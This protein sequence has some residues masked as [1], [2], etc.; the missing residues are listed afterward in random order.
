VVLPGEPEV[1]DVPGRRLTLAQPE[2]HARG[3]AYLDG[4][5]AGL[6]VALGEVSVAGRE[7]PAL[8]ADRDEHSGRSADVAQPSPISQSAADHR[9]DVRVPLVVAG[10]R[11][12]QQRLAPVDPDLMTGHDALPANRPGQPWR[13]RLIYTRGFVKTSGPPPQ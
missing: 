4:R 9:R 6:A 3:G 7:Q 12:L 8:H 11:L 13:C 10:G 1:T 2:A 5:A